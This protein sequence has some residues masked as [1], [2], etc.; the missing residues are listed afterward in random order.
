VSGAFPA[1][2]I[3]SIVAAMQGVAS[4]AVELN[5]THATNPLWPGHAR[6]HVVW[7]SC[8]ALL[9]AAVEVAL[10]WW[11]GPEMRSRFYLA[12]ILI[13]VPM[14][15]FAFAAFFRPLYSGTLRDA[16]GVPPLRARIL[17]RAFELEG[18]VIAVGTGLM[19][20]AIAV[21]LFRLGV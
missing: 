3:L 15:G 6:F 16:N 1:R 5:R 7:Q 11:A 10:I 4:C 21:W 20:L 14:V 19:A 13:A 17:S 8:T 2:V 12:A 9:A 18:N